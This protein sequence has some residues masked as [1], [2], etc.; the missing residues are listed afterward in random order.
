MSAIGKPVSPVRAAGSLIY[1]FREYSLKRRPVV[2]P[3]IQSNIVDDD[4]HFALRLSNLGMTP[5]HARIEKA[6]LRIGDEHYPTPFSQSILLP[7]P[8]RPVPN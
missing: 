6:V 4:W 7:V 8:E 1:A 3:E 2:V 5:A